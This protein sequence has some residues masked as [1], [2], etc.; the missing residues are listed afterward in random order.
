MGVGLHPLWN[1]E[2]IHSKEKKISPPHFPIACQCGAPQEYLSYLRWTVDWLDL[3]QPLIYYSLYPSHSWLMCLNTLSQMVM[4]F[5][6]VVTGSRSLGSGHGVLCLAQF[7][8]SFLL[9]YCQCNMKGRLLAPTTVPS[10]AWWT[11]SPMKLWAK[12]TLSLKFLLEGILSLQ[13]KSNR[14]RNWDWEVE[15]DV[16]VI[17]LAMFQK[18]VVGRV[19]RVWDFRLE[20]LWMP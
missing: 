10:P 16:A 7:L 15:G 12:E 19:G 6:E 8:I 20:S 1:H 13:Q 14:G 17:K 11:V 4:L 5:G 3:V 18:W 9:L 2:C